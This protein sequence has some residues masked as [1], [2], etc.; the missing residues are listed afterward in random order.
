MTN[1]EEQISSGVARRY[2]QRVSGWPHWT[3]PPE[4]L[5]RVRQVN[6]IA[7]DPCWNEHALTGEAHYR[8][9]GSGVDGLAEEWLPY[10]RM[11]CGAKLGL[12]YCNPPYG[13]GI[14][15]WVEK[16]HREGLAGAEAIALLPAR[17][18]TAWFHDWALGA[19]SV[20]FWRGRI[21]FGNPPPGT[22]G[23]QSNVLSVVCYWGKQP[24]RF[25]EA[26]GSAGKVINP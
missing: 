21:Q 15:A 16:C 12:V 14:G 22:K 1:A 20:C 13:P 2:V 3:T 23:N 17:T 25:Q 26:F 4:V 5:S 9:S 7:L 8:F 11:R 6:P 10:T 24:H 19:K 18:D